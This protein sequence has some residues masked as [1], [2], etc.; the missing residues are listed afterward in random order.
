M[1]EYTVLSG[2][3]YKVT[4]DTAEQ[5]IDNFFA[6]YN[7]GDCHCG[8]PQFSDR[9]EYTGDFCECV[10]ESEVLTEVID[11]ES[12]SAIGDDLLTALKT[13]A[14]DS[15]AGVAERATR[16]AGYAIAFEIIN[17]E[18]PTQD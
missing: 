15:S 8:L 3:A 18:P 11:T 12:G 17:G 6:Y 16:R 10:T 9:P 4:A 13:W 5:A 14:D 2:T 1:S 7:G